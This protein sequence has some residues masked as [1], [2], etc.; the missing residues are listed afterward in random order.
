MHAGLAIRRT[1][2]GVLLVLCCVGLVHAVRAAAAHAVY[3]GLKYGKDVVLTPAGLRSAETAHRLY[4]WNF[5][6]SAWVGEQAY[7]RI[8]RA[9]PGQRG[10]WRAIASLWCGRSL[11]MN[12]FKRNMNVLKTR[13]LQME[14]VTDSLAYWRG[15][16]ELNYWSRYNHALLAEL[17]AAAGEFGEAA[18][19]LETARG[20]PGYED[21]RLRVLE[22][23]RKEQQPPVAATIPGG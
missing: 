14:S 21:A 22:A 18:R 10:E 13:L 23:W 11:R 2:G 9:E 19:E 20:G 12:P 17:C 8:H 1:A 16:V 6:L 5:Y 3:C 15:Y 4:P 7:L